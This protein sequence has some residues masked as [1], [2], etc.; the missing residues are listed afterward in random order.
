M[1]LL[2]AITILMHLFYLLHALLIHDD[3]YLWRKRLG[4]F[5]LFDP[6]LYYKYKNGFQFRITNEC[7][8][9]KWKHINYLP[10][11]CCS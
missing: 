9:I 3:F 1:L 5:L 11:G 8:E 6:Q 2:L 7:S 10:L 4:V